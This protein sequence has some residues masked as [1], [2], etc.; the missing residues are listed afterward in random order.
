[1]YNIL[2]NKDKTSNM[3]NIVVVQDGKVVEIYNEA[4]NEERLEGNIYLGKVKNIMPGMQSAFIDIGESKN[5]LVHIKDLIPKASNVTG[6]VFEDTSK[7]NISKIIKSGDEIL[8]QVKRD[9][10]KQKG[11]RVTT[12]IKLYGRFIILLPCSKFITIS[13]KIENK[14]EE[15]RLKNIV[16]N[17]LPKEYGAIIRTVAKNKKE[18]E[19]KKEI[20]FLISMWNSILKNSDSMKNKKMAPIQI[21]NNSGITGKIITDL[22]ENNLEKIYTNEK[23]LKDNYI[24]L[25]DKIEIIDNPLEKFE[26]KKYM[27]PNRKIWLNCGGFITID[28]TEAL[29]AIDVNSAKFTGKR[30][31]EKTVLKVNLEATEEIAKQVRLRDIGGIIIIDYIDMDN[32]EDREKVRN[33]MI[34]C[35]KK[36]RSKVQVMEFTKLGLLEIT[37]KHILGR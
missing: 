1:M 35:F 20:N 34:E 27:N 3:T 29:T 37:R 2:I 36:D 9:C 33:Y 6:N 12:D 31:L 7:M 17:S 24:D 15:K 5:A 28:C 23:E 18:E 30:D 32:E 26:A 4:L 21:F 8:V 25:K 19:I 22:A 13:Q 11:P 14:E 10:N 16:K